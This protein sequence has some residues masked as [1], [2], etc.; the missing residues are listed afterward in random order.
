[1]S[2]VLNSIQHID[3]ISDNERNFTE[4]CRIRAHVEPWLHKDVDEDP[5]APSFYDKDFNIKDPDRWYVDDNAP[6]RVTDEHDSN[7]NQ[8]WG[9]RR[10]KRVNGTAYA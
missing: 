6:D 8:V 2:D 9:S 7:H 1:M 3:D 4:G 5:D 10:D